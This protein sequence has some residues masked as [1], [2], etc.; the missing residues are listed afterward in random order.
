MKF[1]APRIGLISAVVITLSSLTT[2]AYTR[3]T[4]HGARF[5]CADGEQFSATLSPHNARLHIG[6]GVFVL[7]RQPAPS[8]AR[9]TSDEISLWTSG[10]EASLERVGL[11]AQHGCR[12]ATTS[13]L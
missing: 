9:Y 11:P 7:Q 6:S 10:D 8:G 13:R 1:S 4:E 5:V 12:A 2:G 3:E